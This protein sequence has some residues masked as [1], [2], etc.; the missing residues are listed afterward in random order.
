LEK[1]LKICIF[2]N[3]PLIA[4]Y[5]K[6]EIK[7][8]YYNPEN[9]FDE[10]HFITLTDQDIEAAKIQKIAGKA[11]I[12]IHSVGKINIKNRKKYLKEIIEL[13]RKINPDIIRAFNPYVEGWLAANCA[14]KLDKPFFVSLHTQYDYNRKLVKKKNLKKFLV[15]KYLEKFIEPF[16]L[17]NADKITIVYKIIEPYVSKHTSKI[18]ELLYNKIDC[19]KFYNAQQINELSNPLILSV[20]NLIE[21]KNHKLLIKSMQNI[22]ANLLIIGK[23]ELY[24]SLKKIIK[25]MKLENKITILESVPY[26]KITSYYK[27]ADIFALAYDPNQEGLPMPVMEAMA[28]GTPVIV[29]E[30][31]DSKE[32][33]DSIIF[34][35]RNVEEFTKKIDDLL[36]NKTKRDEYSMKC[37]ETAK[38]FD[39]SKLEKREAEIYQELIKNGKTT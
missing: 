5:N 9:F 13:C 6:G 25:I 31:E 19:E 17:G 8:R 39:I 12:V 3:D 20:G 38:R 14:Q 34:A 26:E 28:S 29:P 23:G 21:S 15:L 24:E 27:T 2:P 4:Y 35:K 37:I 22:D 30:S 32:L 18:P 11:K 1:K 33:E 10:V 7:D 36:R 16:V